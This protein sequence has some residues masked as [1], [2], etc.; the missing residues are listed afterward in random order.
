MLYLGILCN[1]ISIF[2]IFELSKINYA[3]T[4]MVKSTL[5]TTAKVLPGNK[6]EIQAPGLSVGQ[7]VEVIIL[8]QEANPSYLSPE[9]QALSLEQRLAF[10]KLPLIECRR[11]LEGQAESMLDHYQQDSEWQQLMSGDSISY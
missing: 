8:V 4:L 9:E 7:T 6:L 2:L 10:L 1:F 3:R 5:D 11:I